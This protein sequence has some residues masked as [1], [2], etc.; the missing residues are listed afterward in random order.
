MKPT[1][2]LRSSSALLL[3]CLV[4]VSVYVLLRGHNAPGGGFIG[5]LIA[6]A[7][8]AVYA[9]SRGRA[10]ALRMLRLHPAAL[11]GL[12]LLVAAASGLPAF[13]DSAAAYLT[14]RWWFPDVG[15]QLPL[16]TPLLF[17]LGVY[18][19]VLGTV[20]AMFLSLVEK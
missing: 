10:A 13:L 4:A 2:I 18:L 3:W 11:C 7:G 5:G 15:I 14:H 6:A 8:V 17:D 1:L 12:G 16:G 19:T 20:T 9:V